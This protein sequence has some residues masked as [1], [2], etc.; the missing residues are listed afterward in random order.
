M[1]SFLYDFTVY[2]AL[3]GGAGGRAGLPSCTGNDLGKLFQ[4]F[5]LQLLIILWSPFLLA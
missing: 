2:T 5:N 1:F 4:M 3:S